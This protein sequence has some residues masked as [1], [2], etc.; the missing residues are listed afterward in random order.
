MRLD[1]LAQLSGPRADLGDGL[2]KI[3]VTVGAKGEVEMREA[4]L[5]ALIA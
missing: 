3:R 2:A 1:A 5:D 4:V